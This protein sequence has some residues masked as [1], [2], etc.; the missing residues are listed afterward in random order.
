MSNPSSNIVTLNTIVEKVNLTY[1]SKFRLPLNI[2][3][4]IDSHWE[5]LSRPNLFNRYEFYLINLNLFW[6]AP[7]LPSSTLT[8]S[9]FNLFKP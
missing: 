6:N 7:D 3:Q 2:I 4:Y 1:F 8:G 9:D 5:I